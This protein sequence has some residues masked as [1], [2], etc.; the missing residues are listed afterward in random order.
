MGYVSAHNNDIISHFLS[1]GALFRKKQHKE[2]RLL[3]WAAVVWCLWGARN[4]VMFTGE[5]VSRE[6]VVNQIK[7][8]SWSW[9]IAKH[10]KGTLVL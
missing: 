9:L 1:H 8:L 7:T 3:I 6:E 10:F 2:V 5:T 4:K